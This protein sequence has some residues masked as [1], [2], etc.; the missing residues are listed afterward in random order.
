MHRKDSHGP[1]APRKPWQQ[2]ELVEVLLG[3]V[4]LKGGAAQL[5]SPV[6]APRR[7]PWTRPGRARRR[8]RGGGITEL[9]IKLPSGMLGTESE[10]TA[11]LPL[12]GVLM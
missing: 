9:G 2:S 7:P 3:G 6:P 8:R 1:T 12:G 11:F 4:H 5:P 10:R